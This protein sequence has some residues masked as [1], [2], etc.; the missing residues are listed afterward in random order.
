M[1][2]PSRLYK[3]ESLTVQTLRNLK[4]QVLYFGSPQDFADPYDCALTPNIR[5]P[6]DAEVESVRKLY[7]EK[8]S[9]SSLEREQLESVSDVEF[10]DI[11]MRMSDLFEKH[12]SEFR[13]ERGVTCFSEVNDDLLMWSHYGGRYKGICLEFSTESR[14][15]DTFDKIRQVHY[16]ETPPELD[17]ARILVE[18]DFGAIIDDLFCTKSVSWSYE[19]EWRAI[20][21]TAGQEYIYPTEALTGVFFGPDIDARSM[22]IVCLILRSQNESVRFWRGT[23]STTEFRVL[24]SEFTYM[25]FLEARRQGMV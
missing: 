23:C 11:L 24:F 7:L 15:F 13:K 21:K 17:L 8:P 10:R 25:S 2:A 20:H 18:R 4:G 3:Y 16:V 14:P 5:T 1:P 9:T 6:S 19:R 22:E 12:V